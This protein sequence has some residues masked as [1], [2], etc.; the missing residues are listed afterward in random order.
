MPPVLRLVLV[1]QPQEG[2]SKNYEQRILDNK[3]GHAVGAFKNI[4][5]ENQVNLECS[6]NSKSF[7][8]PFSTA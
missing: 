1:F 7:K 5:T 2:L 3:A 6:L 8:L 4:L